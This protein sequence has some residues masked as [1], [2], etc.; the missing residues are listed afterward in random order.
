MK[1][2][3]L[4]IRI[5]LKYIHKIIYLDKIFLIFILLFYIKYIKIR[6]FKLSMVLLSTMQIN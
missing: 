5:K 3:S 4:I 6:S 2:R 1:I